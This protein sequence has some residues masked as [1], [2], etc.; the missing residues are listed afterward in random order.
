MKQHTSFSY[1]PETHTTTCT[2]RVRDTYFVGTAKCHPQDY[3][4]ENKLT[5]EHYSYM[6]TVIKEAQQVRDE[7]KQQLKILKHVY[8]LFEQ[9]NQIDL[10]SQE[11]YYVKK[12]IENV[13][14]NINEFKE[15][16]GALKEN[17]YL[18]I[19]NKNE[20]YIKIRKARVGNN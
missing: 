19:E 8:S 5:G 2:R 6:R 4:F 9:N 14:N 15:L 10:H 18:T 20:M 1:D 12:Q 7:Y 17:L 3:D 11:C 16:I 13:Q